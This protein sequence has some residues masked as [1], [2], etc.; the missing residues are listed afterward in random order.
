MIDA[1]AFGAELAAI[2]QRATAPLQQL[3]EAQA[4]RIA[5]LEKAIA[6]MPAPQDGA[7]GA[8]VTLGD[9]LPDL[10]KQVDEFLAALPVPQD[11]KDGAPG[12]DGV[13]G[14]PGADGASVTADDVLPVIG[15]R[16]DEYLAALPVPQDGKDGAP[17]RDGADGAPGADGSSVTADD[18]LPVIGKRVDEYLAALP[19]P[20]DGKDGAPGRDGVDGAP[21]ADGADGVS[22][23][24]AMIDRKG[25]LVVTLSNGTLCELGIVAGNDGAPGADGQDGLGFEDLDFSSDGHGRPVAVFRRGGAEKSV[26]LPCIIDRGPF[27][28]GGSYEKGDAVSYGGSMW[29]AQ[30]DGASERPD[31]GAGW[32]LAVKRGRDA[33][34]PKVGTNA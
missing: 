2:V 20:Q 18:L 29:I 32:R 33:R 24:G 31:G 23:A 14:A 19:V 21:G 15:K 13:D 27:R 30:E 9:V 7:D 26:R 8:S 28:S 12:R 5:D 25:A 22:L 17:G 1:K 4:A 11:G 10:Q 6:A 16:V 34:E 3:I